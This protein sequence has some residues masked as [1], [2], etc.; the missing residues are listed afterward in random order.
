MRV[1]SHDQDLRRLNRMALL[2]DDQIAA[3]QIFLRAHL[4]ALRAVESALADAGLPPLA[5]YDVLWAVRRAPQQRARVGELASGLVLSHGW[6]S[7]LVDRLVADGLVRRERSSADGRASEIVLTRDGAETLRRMWPVY[8]DAIEA[9]F[10]S[11]LADATTLATLLRPI[12]AGA[13]ASGDAPA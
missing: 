12:A 4:A 5:W 8:S 6:L 9:A 10:S 11:R 1:Y 7:R 2:D 3:W 13:V